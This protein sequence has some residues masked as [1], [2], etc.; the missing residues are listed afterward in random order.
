MNRLMNPTFRPFIFLFLF[1]PIASTSAQAASRYVRQGASGAGDG[2]DWTN[3]YPSLPGSLTRGDTYYIADGNYGAYDFNTPASGTTL[4]IVRKATITDHGTNTGWN[5]SYGDGQA[6]FS[7]DSSVGSDDWLIDGVIGGGPGSW[8]SGH[9]FKFQCLTNCGP[10]LMLNN[11]NVTMRHLEVLGNGDDGSGSQNDCFSF[12]PLNPGARNYTISH[13]WCHDTG[14][15]SFWL[16]SGP[17][18]LEHGWF[19][20]FEGNNE[21]EHAEVAANWGGDLTVR[22]SVLTHCEGTGGIMFMDSSSAMTNTVQIYGNIFV[23]EERLTNPGTG[24]QW[25]ACAHGLIG[26]NIT[27]LNAMHLRVFNNTFVDTASQV[28][29]GWS[30]TTLGTIIQGSPTDNL[31]R[32]NL[33]YNSGGVSFNAFSTVADNHFVN[34]GSA[35]GTNSSTG[36][37]DPF[38]NWQG[39]NF[40]LKAATPGCSPMISPY[41]LDMLGN[42]R[43]ADS[44]WDRGAIE[45]GGA[46]PTPPAAP[47]NLRI[48]P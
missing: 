13:F 47:T 41:N 22:W 25:T 21:P 39:E 42:V 20:R 6:V 43:G 16:A 8:R 18:T 28:P 27:P 46:S 14:R 36:S 12:Y 23:P 19:G 11:D 31:A 32:C 35:G 3:A 44:T 30:G 29:G 10:V 4:I 45:F 1:V 38:I 26:F 24:E 33:W 9:G 2:S 34:S 37:G 7:G 40:A 17:V 48:T 5:N 15:T